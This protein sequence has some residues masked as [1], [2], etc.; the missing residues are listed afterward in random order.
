M[1]L[2][3]RQVLVTYND[4]HEM[5]NNNKSSILFWIP[6]TNW[7]NPAKLGT[8]KVLFIQDSVYSVFCLYRIQYIQCLVYTGFSIFSVWFIQDSVYSV[9]GLYR[10][11]YIQCLVYTGFRIFSVWFIQDSVYSV[12][13]LYKFHYLCTWLLHGCFCLAGNV[14]F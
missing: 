5:K 10:I 12:F 3:R 13:G 4:D 2:L 14:L 8:S 6:C 7:L 9:F 1:I 11:Q